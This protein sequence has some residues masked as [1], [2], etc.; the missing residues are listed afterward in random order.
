[1]A[2]DMKVEHI[3]EGT[4]GPNFPLVY[5]DNVLNVAPGEDTVK[6]YL[7]RIEP[8]FMVT[9][10][11]RNQA[12]M[13]LGGFVSTALFFGDVLKQMLE[14]GLITQDYLDNLHKT[15]GE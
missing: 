5:A 6:F 4:P 8:N 10:T 7:S 9:E 15:A 11:Y 2:D 12:V 3:S 13:P 14:T 1:M